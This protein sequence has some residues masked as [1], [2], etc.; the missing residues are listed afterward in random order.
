MAFQISFAGMP[1][2][3][4]YAGLVPG[5]L[6]LYQFNVVVPNVAS[7]DAV[8]VTFTLGGASGPQT[9]LIPVQD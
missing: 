6:G 3:V 5:Y 7:S 1:A 2:S 9:L 8:P 4:P